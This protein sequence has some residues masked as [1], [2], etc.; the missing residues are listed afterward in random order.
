[1]W[2]KKTS[3]GTLP[4]GPH[5]ARTKVLQN[6]ASKPKEKNTVSHGQPGRVEKPSG[7]IGF[8]LM[9]SL[10]EPKDWVLRNLPQAKANDSCSGR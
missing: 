6:K 8:C 9:L 3:L 10:L 4:F 7:F 2:T 5:R 1:M